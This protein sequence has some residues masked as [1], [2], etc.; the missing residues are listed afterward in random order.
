[1][2][3]TKIK[4]FPVEFPVEVRIKLV[5]ALH[6]IE[7]RLC[8]GASEKIQLTALISAFALAKEQIAKKAQE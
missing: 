6:N 1:M 3:P 4:K 8:A 7:N 2:N 5:I